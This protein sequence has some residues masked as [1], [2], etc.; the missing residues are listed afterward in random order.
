MMK[1]GAVSR[2]GSAAV[3]VVVAGLELTW[4]YA[5][6]HTFNDG[7]SLNVPVSALLLVYVASFAWAAVLRRICRSSRAVALASWSVWPLAA[8]FATTIS[9]YP[10][11]APA[12]STWT[13]I[14]EAFR[15][16]ALR[17]GTAV[18]LIVASGALWWLGARVVGVRITH[19]SV[20][21]R[22]SIGLT[23]LALSLLVGYLVG[24]DESVAA[25]TVIIFTGLALGAAAMSRGADGRGPSVSRQGGAWWGMLAAGLA[26]VLGVG[27]AIAALV[28]PDLM[29]LIGR[30]L[31]GLWGLIEG[32]LRA[33][34]SM[35]CSGDSQTAGGTPPSDSHSLP[36]GVGEMSEV[37]GGGAPSRTGLIVLGSVVGVSALLLGGLLVAHLIAWMRGTGRDKA[38]IEHLPAGFRID[39]KK[40]FLRFAAWL[41]GLKLFGR[42]RRDSVQESTQSGQMRRLYADM[43]RW[44]AKAGLP[45]VPSET[46]FEYQ[47]T[48][49]AA[50]PA[51][52]AEVGHITGSYVMT[53]YAAQPPTELELRRLRETW[54]KVKRRAPRRVDTGRLVG[55]R[56]RVAREVE[57]H[58][59]GHG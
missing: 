25:P 29:S 41:S 50:L 38:E 55:S 3:A 12:N 43:L 2:R 23:V 27:L 39:V 59:D 42:W 47:A 9:L 7:L 21:A 24:T 51:Y 33:I 31:R 26:T 11:A 30:G 54:R 6:L 44:G 28:T 14:A 19:R 45:R 18:F 35:S 40:L 15:G 53:K 20:L 8:L 34:G 37:Q 49:S 56:S 57:E 52:G 36:V 5:L 13:T 10:H 32:L 58:D 22:V 48:L 1:A 4:V 16:I 17:P 46:P